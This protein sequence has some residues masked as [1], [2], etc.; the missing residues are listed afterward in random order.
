MSAATGY[1]WVDVRHHNCSQENLVENLIQTARSAFINFMNKKS[2]PPV[3]PHK[4]VTFYTVIKYGRR[5]Y[6]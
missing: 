1:L 6:Y 5:C 2:A 4:D 3:V